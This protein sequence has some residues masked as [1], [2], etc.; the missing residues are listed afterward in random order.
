MC[1]Q[2]MLSD[3]NLPSGGAST[4]PVS[5]ASAPA[6]A[7]ATSF[8][9]HNSLCADSRSRLKRLSRRKMY[10]S[11]TQAKTQR[12]AASEVSCNSPFG[13]LRR[14]GGFTNHQLVK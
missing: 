14:P 12:D 9:R 2:A 3:E 11:W 10:E 7:E 4:A 5:S 13:A 6:S 1:M 8:K